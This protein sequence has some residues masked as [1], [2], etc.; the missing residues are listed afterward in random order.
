MGERANGMDRV[1]SQCHDLHTC[2]QPASRVDYL[3]CS[4]VVLQITTHD[5]RSPSADLASRVVRDR[6]AR[7]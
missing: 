6:L 2:M 3:T 4:R 1:W 7:G 5:L